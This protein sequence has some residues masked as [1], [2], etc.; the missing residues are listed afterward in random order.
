MPNGKTYLLTALLISCLPRSVNVVADFS[1]GYDAYRAGDYKAA[2]SVWKASAEK[3]D[4]D[5]Q[6][7]L[8]SIYSDG[9]G[10]LQ[11]YEEA[12]KWY[13]KAAEQGHEMAQLKLGNVYR[14]GKG[15]LQDYEEAVKWYTKAAEQ[16]SDLAQFNL[17]AIHAH[18]AGVREDYKEA[19][20]WYTKAAEQGY[21]RAQANLGLM[22]ASGAG[23]LQDN[24]YAHMWLNIANAISDAGIDGDEL[25]RKNRDILASKMTPAEIAEAQK[26][27]RECI[28]KDFKNC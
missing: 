28:K 25:A 19:V 7:V 6:Y 1:D 11:D 24:V 26:L 12:V 15:V 3:G 20:K 8:G 2:V 4:I 10:V 22:Y 23:V 14:D 18:T 21:F 5:S 9:K 17:G 27:A 13:T 16:G